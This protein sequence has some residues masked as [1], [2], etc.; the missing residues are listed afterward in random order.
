MHWRRDFLLGSGVLSF[1]C[2]WRSRLTQ[3]TSGRDHLISLMSS[4]G[5]FVS[6]IDTIPGFLEEGHWSLGFYISSWGTTASFYMAGCRDILAGFLE[7]PQ[8]WPFG[9]FPV[10]SFLVAFWLG[11][12]MFQLAFQ[13]IEQQTWRHLGLY[14]SKVFCAETLASSF[15]KNCGGTLTVGSVST[16][17]YR[18]SRLHPE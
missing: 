9:E 5:G 1:L 10:G 2:L 16:L 18:L 13:Q 15:L 8:W 4:E 3:K 14:G 6:F 17:A 11:Q 7:S 12:L